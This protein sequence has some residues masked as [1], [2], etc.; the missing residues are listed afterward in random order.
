VRTKY[1]ACP[2]LKLIA[3]N[4]EVI[5]VRNES[6]QEIVILDA[7]EYSHVGRNKPVRAVARTEVSGN[8]TYNALQSD[9]VTVAETFNLKQELD[10]P[11][12]DARQAAI[13]R[14]PLFRDRKIVGFMKIGI[15][16]SADVERIVTEINDTTSN[17]IVLVF[18]VAAD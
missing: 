5:S 18:V 4:H 12:F 2:R 7:K 13:Q 8:T 14:S 15:G 9:K 17:Q 10:D 1:Q 11:A 3:K 16:N 6:E